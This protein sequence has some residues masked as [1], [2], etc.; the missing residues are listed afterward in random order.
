ML[1]PCLR[2]PCRTAPL[3]PVAQMNVP[4]SL[5]TRWG[6]EE[7]DDWQGF[8]YVGSTDTGYHIFQDVKMYMRY[9]VYKFDANVFFNERVWVNEYDRNPGDPPEVVAFIKA[10]YN[11]IQ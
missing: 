9:I 10:H 8:L 6:R 1:H 7:D 2:I 5:L 4:Q 3:S 11:L